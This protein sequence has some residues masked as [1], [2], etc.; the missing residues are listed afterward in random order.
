MCFKCV[1]ASE[2]KDHKPWH[3]VCV[4]VSDPKSLPQI[5]VFFFFWRKLNFFL[6]SDNIL[7]MEIKLK[8]LPNLNDIYLILRHVECG[9]N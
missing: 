4:G 3:C 5:N 7:A 8:L 2:A 1:C 6:L 9:K